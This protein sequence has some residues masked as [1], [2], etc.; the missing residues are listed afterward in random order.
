MFGADPLAAPA[1]D[2]IVEPE[3]YRTCRHE[4]VQQQA[5]QHPRHRSPVPDGTGRHW[6]TCANGLPGAAV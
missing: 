4:T 6:N 3:Q 2:R 1:L 5:K